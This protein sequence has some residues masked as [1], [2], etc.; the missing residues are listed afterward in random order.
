MKENKVW[1]HCGHTK[2]SHKFGVDCEVPNCA[3]LEFK[4]R[5]TLPRRKRATPKKLTLRQ[6]VFAYINDELLDSNTSI[7][8]SLQEDPATVSSLTNRMVK[9][10]TLGRLKSSWGTWFYHIPVNKH[11]ARLQLQIW[12]LAE[13]VNE[14]RRDY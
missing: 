10:G 14:T 12:D 3:C 1:C 7:A 13:R 2:S 4:E 9:E 11:L 6:R 8:R 5:A